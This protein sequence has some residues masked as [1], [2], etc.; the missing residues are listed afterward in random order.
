LVASW[1][2]DSAKVTFNAGE[3]RFPG[4]NETRLT[5]ERLV[6]DAVKPSDLPRPVADNGGFIHWSL[7][8]GTMVAPDAVVEN[9]ND[10]ELVAQYGAWVT[11]TLDLQG[12][13]WPGNTDPDEQDDEPG[14]QIVVPFGG[15]Y[16]ADGAI[17]DPVRDN[18]AFIRWNVINPADPAD[19]TDDIQLTRWPVN[20]ADPHTIVAEWLQ[21]YEVAFDANAP[22]YRTSSVMEMPTTPLT[23]TENLDY[24]ELPQP[25]LAGYTFDGWFTTADTSGI[26]AIGLND[27]SDRKPSQAGAWS[28]DATARTDTLYAKWNANEITVTFDD[29]HPGGGT[30]NQ[31][32][33]VDGEYTTPTPNP[34]R[35][36]YTFAGWNQAEGGGESAVSAGDRVVKTD[37][38]TVYAQWDAITYNV[39]YQSGIEDL[40]F[41]DENN[42]AIDDVVIEQVEFGTAYPSLVDL[43]LTL[44][45]PGYVLSGWR[46]DGGTD[47][48]DLPAAMMV[49]ADH[50]VEAVWVKADL[51]VEVC[52][53]LSGC[54]EGDFVAY[55]ARV[56]SAYSGFVLERLEDPNGDYWHA[57]WTFYPTESPA[58]SQDIVDTNVAPEDVL[59]PDDH[60]IEPL[61]MER[62]A[63]TLDGNHP[64]PSLG[65]SVTLPSGAY[66]VA[67]GEPYPSIDNASLE[68][69][70]FQGWGLTPETTNV[71][72]LAAQSTTDAPHT[73]YAIWLGNGVEVTFDPNPL[74]PED[75][76]LT[77]QTFGTAYSTA[78]LT[79]PTPTQSGFTFS[80]WYLDDDGSE[81]FDGP[82]VTDAA[83]NAVDGAYV[84]DTNPHTVYATWTP[85]EYNVTIDL[86]GGSWPSGGSPSDADTSTPETDIVRLYTDAY[87]RDGAIPDPERAGYVFQFWSV[88]QL[89]GSH[90]LE[91]VLPSSPLRYAGDHKLEAQWRKQHDITLDGNAPAGRS[92]LVSPSTITVTEGITVPALPIPEVPGYTFS[93][94]YPSQDSVSNANE[95]IQGEGDPQPSGVPLWEQD[96]GTPWTT[97]YAGWTA[98]TVTVTYDDNHDSGGATEIDVTVDGA[99]E[100]PDA[101][102]NRP[103]YTFAGWNTANDG[104]GDTVADTSTVTATNNHTLYAQ[105]TYDGQSAAWVGGTAAAAPTGSFTLDGVTFNVTSTTEG[106]AGNGT[107]VRLVGALQTPDPSSTTL[108]ATTPAAA[109]QNGNTATAYA[110]FGTAAPTDVKAAI[111]SLTDAGGN[112][113]YAVDVVGSDGSPLTVASQSSSST[114]KASTM[115]YACARSTMTVRRTRTLSFRLKTS[116]P[117]KVHHFSRKSVHQ[118]HLTWN[119]RPTLPLQRRILSTP[120][121]ARR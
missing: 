81:P 44:E 23:V 100:H 4:L 80:G 20:Y 63:L 2:T 84:E 33:K 57:G 78:G 59:L 114:L 5:R 3:G 55:N 38:H 85:N 41:K 120:S 117:L 9:T 74:A 39:S 72:G 97:L 19:G 91:D 36:G 11:V 17:V 50:T 54:S 40:Q 98:N 13:R 16:D 82:Q 51:T 56:G 60:R 58:S 96:N 71:I 53:I 42:N 115:R 88:V 66:R 62:H 86:Q 52:M 37:N 119:F 26:E 21:K 110:R 75:E 90:V 29:N 116:L 64:N 77:T 73:L 24:P 108:D 7:T 95:R 49:A 69:Y 35:I 12:G 118:A 8:D 10:L 105:W 111:E 121:M 107:G 65:S 87:N 70:T 18:F 6:G 30:K 45:R 14:S 46:I 103:N 43:G 102:S 67:Q 93:G 113:L 92:T 83:G 68:G 104:S 48:Q 109:L 89:D 22:E 112:P 79:T 25:S 101:P 28:D 27:P 15:V 34:E 94:W 106:S 61:S 47:P 99:Y 32:L 1:Q 31:R 76:T